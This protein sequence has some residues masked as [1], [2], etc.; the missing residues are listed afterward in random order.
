M[1]STPASSSSR[2]FLTSLLRAASKISWLRRRCAIP[3][4]SRS[5]LGLP[6]KAKTARG[7]DAAA[8][9]HRRRVST[10]PWNRRRRTQGCGRSSTPRD[11][12]APVARVLQADQEGRRKGAGS[13]CVC[14]ACAGARRVPCR[15]RRS[16]RARR[17]ARACGARRAV[18]PPGARSKPCGCVC[19]RSQ[20][21]G[22]PHRH[23]AAKG[24]CAHRHARCFC[25]DFQRRERVLCPL[26]RSARCWALRRSRTHCARSIAR[27]GCTRAD[28]VCVACCEPCSE[29]G[30]RR[31]CLRSCRVPAARRVDASVRARSSVLCAAA[32]C[33]RV[34]CAER[35]A[36]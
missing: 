12:A 23:A 29:G 13:R 34:P 36:C 14:R 24:R 16:V 3:Q 1:G 9:D 32:A 20:G 8:H 31:T 7:T 27:D 19:C 21:C 2:T 25:C 18:F 28:A 4:S 22:G 11:T 5:L 35:G 33:Q 30:R 10:V 6:P 15:V 17:R 26:W